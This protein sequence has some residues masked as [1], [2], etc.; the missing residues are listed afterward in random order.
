L[1]S[2]LGTACRFGHS[3][4]TPSSEHGTSARKPRG[5]VIRTDHPLNRSRDTIFE[6][7]M[8]RLA[9][10]EVKLSVPRRRCRPDR[11][12]TGEHAGQ[13]EV[14][15]EPVGCDRDKEMRSDMADTRRLPGPSTESWDWQLQARCRGLDSAY[16]FHPDNERGAARAARV[17]R[18]KAICRRCPVRRECRQH[19]LA[20]Q[21]PYG[22]WGGLTEHERETLLRTRSR[23]LLMG[24]AHR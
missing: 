10:E 23:P 8:A 6:Q 9:K 18:A 12:P 1:A 20:A 7:H 22:I 3:G 21:E 2:G 16:F 5:P 11:V 19:A 14:S 4:I 13:A 24:T 17:S 15:R